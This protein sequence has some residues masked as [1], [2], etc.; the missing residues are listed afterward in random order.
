MSANRRELHHQPRTLTVQRFA[1]VTT[2]HRRALVPEQRLDRA[3]IRPV[4]GRVLDHAV[5]EE[6]RVHSLDP[7]ALPRAALD[8][9]QTAVR[10][11][12][13]PPGHPQLVG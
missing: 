4:V 12:P 7:A 9:I 2:R 3:N 8:H 6:V 5:T 13:T 1:R 11:W 10:E